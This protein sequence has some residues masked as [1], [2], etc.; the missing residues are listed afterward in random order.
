MT[1]L[2][3]RSLNF[4]GSDTHAMSLFPSYIGSVALC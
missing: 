3:T 4:G 1:R 2:T